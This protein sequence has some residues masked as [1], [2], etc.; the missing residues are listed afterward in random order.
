MLT[1]N[2]TSRRSAGFRTNGSN[3]NQR[4]TSNAF[5]ANWAATFL[6]KRGRISI[7]G[8]YD[9]VTRAQWRERL[10]H[11]SHDLWRQRHEHDRGR[12]P[13]GDPAGGNFL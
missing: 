6:Q 11:R 2:V 12:A 1:P 3:N 7:G 10:R 4:F 9:D 5:Y 8:R 13:P